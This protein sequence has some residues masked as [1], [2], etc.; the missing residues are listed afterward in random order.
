MG[1][2][3]GA[4]IE[5]AQCSRVW[6]KPLLT[7][8]F[9]EGATP[10]AVVG[11]FYHILDSPKKAFLIGFWVLGN[12]DEH[13]GQYRC[14]ANVSPPW[15][16]SLSSTLLSKHFNWPQDGCNPNQRIAYPRTAGIE[17]QLEI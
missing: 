7:R 13:I 10:L 9:F 3:F 1:L 8:A 17:L 14:T 12:F 11:L 4:E 16:R 5:P 6:S 2:S 15:A